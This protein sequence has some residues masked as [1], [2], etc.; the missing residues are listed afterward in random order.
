MMRARELF[1]ATKVK[2]STSKKEMGAWVDDQEQDEPT[3]MIDLK[4]IISVLEPDELHDTKP[5]A[6]KRV[7]DM[8]KQLEKGKDTPPVLVRKYKSGYQIL[9]GHHRFKA[10]KKANKEQ[11]PA[12]IVAA[13][14]ITDVTDR[15]E[16]GENIDELD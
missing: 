8:V 2:I 7:D 10:Y 4:S 6:K 5:D 12:Q 9:D 1:E 14:N 15:V 3:V 11:I 13:K 16:R